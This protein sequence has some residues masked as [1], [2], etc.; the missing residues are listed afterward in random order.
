M[1][2]M[3]RVE[4]SLVVCTDCGKVHR[5][6]LLEGGQIARCAR[7]DA[8]LGRGH[9]LGTNAVL[10]LTTAAAATFVVAV[11]TPLLSLSFRGG[12]ETATLLDTIGGAWQAGYPLIAVVAALTALLAPAALIL[13]RLYVLAP[14]SLGHKPPGFAWCVRLLHQA[15][16]WSMVGVFTIGVL[17]SLVR[18]AAL[19]DASPGPGLYALGAVTVLLA[20]IESA[21]LKHLWWS[22]R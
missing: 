22:V 8:I 19:A 17:L 15:G 5:W 3:S 14:L 16:R 13:L 11:S 9:R 10:A 4:D 2:A 1:V 21:G 6:Q 20:A 18:L 12:S 7:C